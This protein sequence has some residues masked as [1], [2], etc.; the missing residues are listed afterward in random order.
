MTDYLAL[1]QEARELAAKATPGPWESDT[2]QYLDEV[3]WAPAE[4]WIANVGNCIQPVVLEWEDL[5]DHGKMICQAQ[6]DN[7]KF[8]ARA[9]ELVPALADA[10]EQLTARIEELEMN[11]YFMVHGGL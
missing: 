8:I 7:C 3:V 2:V 11:L 5:T 10:V 9:R 6:D 1:V 4:E